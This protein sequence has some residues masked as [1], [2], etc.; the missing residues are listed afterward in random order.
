MIVFLNFCNGTF[1]THHGSLEGSRTDG[2]NI[3]VSLDKLTRQNLGRHFSKP[4]FSPNAVRW[5]DAFVSWL[6]AA[7]L[8]E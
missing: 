7:L 8:E 5:V 4:L 1:I 3:D 6:T 2:I